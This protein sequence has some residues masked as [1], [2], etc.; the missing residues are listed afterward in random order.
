MQV[1]VFSGGIVVSYSI[2]WKDFK[3]YNKSEQLLA[4]LK[5]QPYKHT[6]YYHYTSLDN[7]NRILESNSFRIF[8]VVGFNDEEDKKQYVNEQH[9]VFCLCFSTGVN[10]NLPLWYLYSGISGKG[11]RVGFT[12]SKIEKLIH[13]SIYTLHKLTYKENGR[14]ELDEN[15]LLTLKQGVSMEM[16]F[17]DMVYSRFDDKKN[18][19]QLKY[20]NMTNYNFKKAEFEKFKNQY[21]GFNKGLIWFYEKETRLYIKLIGEATDLVQDSTNAVTAQYAIKMTFPAEIKKEIEIML[22]PEIKDFSEL[23]IQ[24]YYSIIDLK[25]KTSNV[26]LSYYKGGIKMNLCGRCDKINKGETK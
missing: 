2:E 5:K 16:E 9:K 22:A 3:K 15:V 19:W 17:R 23:D 7:A 1:L 11:A 20:N 26:K 18:N 13:D 14:A 12:S 4:Y 21:R 8:P 6:H 25:K 10:E 24:K